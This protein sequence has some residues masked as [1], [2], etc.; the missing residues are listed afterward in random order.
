MSILT[1]SPHSGQLES[2]VDRFFREQRIGALLKR[3]NFGKA[4][5]FS[6]LYLLKFV[7]LL[8]FTGKNLYRLLQ[9]EA[10][11]GQRPGKDA[12]YRFLNSCHYN[13]RRLLL[14][15]AAG[16]V[17]QVQSLT[18]AERVK[19]LV[20]DDSL[21]SRGRSKTV[22]LLARV[23]DHVDNKYVRGFRMLTV[24]WSDG[25]TFLPLC[26]SL[27]SSEK[28]ENRLQEANAELDK[29]TVGYQR[30]QES[31]RKAPDVLL[32]LLQQVLGAGV[33][34]TYV[35]FDSWFAFPGTIQ[36]I[37]DQGLH[38]ICMLKAM[39]T[40]KYRYNG[41]ALTL[42]QLF[43]AV[44]KR[45]GKAKILASVVV[46][47]GKN[48]QGEPVQA[49][50]VFVRDRRN[51]RKWLALLCTDLSLPEEEV[52]RIYGKRWDIEV[53][54]K[55]T[56]SYLNLAKEFQGCSYDMMVAH[57]SIVFL[58]Y[59][60]LAQDAREAADPRTLGNL[61]YACC[62]ELQDLTFAS[63][64]MMLMDLLKQAIRKVLVLTDEMF[65]RIFAHFVEA[66]PP[67]YRRS[68]GISPCE[69]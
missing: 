32:E 3:C 8:A 25:N 45:P 7:F 26:F 43:T 48:A 65:D 51:S 54:F 66:L 29:R 14:L 52:V 67:V 16:M 20:V 1:Q 68:L 55:M 30:R 36:R 39:R 18:S 33:E 34:A 49:R 6:C 27:L 5:G 56:K 17:K 23:F 38:V 53:F 60:M 37:R 44:K 28:P 12:V 31:M 9:T 24:G 63:A 15:L 50:I 69:S 11:D 46:T 40:V 13:W 62:D 41:K 22:E 35:L 19:V 61:F 42:T 10:P 47:L 57:T 64:L 21:F 59:M 58:R 4:A 2:R